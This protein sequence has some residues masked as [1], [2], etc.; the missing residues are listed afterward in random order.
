MLIRPTT[1]A[2]EPVP[3]PEIL[4]AELA[5]ALRTG[6]TLAAL[7]RCTTIL[8]LT[9]TRATAASD[10]TPDRATAAHG[11][12]KTAAV[13]VD[14]GDRGGPHSVL[15]ALAPGYRG[16]LLKRRWRDVA[17]ALDVTP[18]HARDYLK[19]R[20]LEAVADELYARDSAYRLRHRHRTQRERQPIDNRIGVNWLA[21]HEAYRRV[22]TP[23]AALRADLQVLLE[24][25]R[26]AGTE[27]SD[28]VDRL[29]NMSWRLAQFSVQLE[30][31]V[32][33]H[34]GLWVLADIESEIAA[35]AAIR[36]LLYHLP[37]GETDLSW[38]RL[39]LGQSVGEELHGFI[40]ALHPT[41]RGRELTAAWLDWAKTC[42]CDSAA[43]DP[44]SCDVH[45][46][47]AAADEFI[48]L[49]DDDWYRVAD[50]YRH[51]VDPHTA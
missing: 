11:L 6:I 16:S 26:G 25:L 14:D 46:W 5:G 49:I 1:M 3:S 24:Y 44:S 35:A 39:I 8:D 50:W 2:A 13:L 34:G 7:A 37:L 43:P 20:M 19:E 28:I 15:L 48:R 42:T 33:E 38:L 40:D 12:I 41:D 21:Q 23:V 4:A 9:L 18:D 29:M 17:D 22:W 27:S 31:F 36:R 45:T 30:R 47:I 10:R 51:V 32:Q